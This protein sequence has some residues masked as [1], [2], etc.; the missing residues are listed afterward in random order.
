MKLEFHQLDLRYGGLRVR[1]N[2][3]EKHLLG[4]IGSSGQQV[5]IIVVAE[6]ETPDR[7][8]VIDGFKRIRALER[9]GEDT[10]EAIAWDLPEAHALL[11]TQS[12]RSSRG[13]T[14]LEEGWLLHELHRSFAWMPAPVESDHRFRLNLIT[15]SNRK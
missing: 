10:V 15:D 6:P 9:L 8:L 12:L 1:S 13:D 5:P 2:P 4:S 11:L 7:F 3:Q 14:P